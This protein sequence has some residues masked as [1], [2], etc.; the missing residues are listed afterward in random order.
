VAGLVDEAHRIKLSGVDGEFRVVFGV[1]DEV[2]AMSKGA[3][4]AKT[5]LPL[6]AKS[7]SSN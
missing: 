1:A 7:V 4:F 6:K 2:D 5:T 3:K